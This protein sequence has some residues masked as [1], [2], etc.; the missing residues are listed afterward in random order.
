MRLKYLAILSLSLFVLAACAPAVVTPASTAT[1][2]PQ[3]VPATAA[4][5]QQPNTPVPATNTAAPTATT[6]PT[7]A[8]PTPTST[9]SATATKSA[10]TPTVAAT[11]AATK[12]ATQ[13]AVR[14]TSTSSGPLAAAIYV[15][16]CRSEPTT[17]KPGQVIIQISVE[18]TG[19]NGVYQYF[20]Q[21]KEQPSKFIDVIGE[22][23]TR[24]IGYVDVQSGGQTLKKTFN[25][26]VADLTCP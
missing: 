24:V 3:L 16:N 14:P 5:T 13:P 8:A 1:P 4:P 23:G 21:G 10:A 26:S 19:G 22:R 9:A 18:A 7:R 25:I 20:Y 12:P 15:A 17:D 2:V 11:A 6:Q